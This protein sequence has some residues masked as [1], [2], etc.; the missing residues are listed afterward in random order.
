MAIFFSAML[1]LMGIVHLPDYKFYWSGNK[2]LGNVGMKEIMPKARYEKLSQYLHLNDSGHDQQNDK[3]YKVKPFLNAV[4]EKCLSVYKP[5]Q[6]Q[7]VDEGM[8]PYKGRFTCKQY[9]PSK[10]VKWGIKA[11]MRCDSVTGIVHI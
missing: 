11:W 7:C 5:K 3:L 10:P 1:I 4:Q 2:Y 8:I 9:M 6:N